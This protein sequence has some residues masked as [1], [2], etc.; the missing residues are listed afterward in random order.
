[1]KGHIAF[2]KKHINFSFNRSR[3]L[4]VTVWRPLKKSPQNMYLYEC[5]AVFGIE[6]KGFLYFCRFDSIQLFVGS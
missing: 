4:H 6:S 2:P 5:L 1:M 3:E